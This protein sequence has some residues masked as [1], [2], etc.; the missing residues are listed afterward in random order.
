[1]LDDAL[2]V[3]VVHGEPLNYL[4][5]D[6][7]VV[8]VRIFSLSKGVWIVPRRRMMLV[9]VCHLGVALSDLQILRLLDVHAEQLRDGAGALSGIEIEIMGYSVMAKVIVIEVALVIRAK[10]ALR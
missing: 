3:L 7:E 9:L 10:V 5:V 1:M 8:N 4:M 6:V 2:T